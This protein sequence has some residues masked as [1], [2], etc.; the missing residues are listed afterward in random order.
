MKKKFGHNED[1]KI[2]ATM[3]D[4]SVPVSKP[5]G[6]GS[7]GGGGQDVQLHISMI[8]NISKGKGGKT[9]E[10]MCSVWPD[11]IEINKLFIRKLENVLAQPYTGPEFKYEH[12]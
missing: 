1:I 10:I 4:G 7:G 2:E 5:G 9:L 11:T 3:F 12:I 6:T 8:V